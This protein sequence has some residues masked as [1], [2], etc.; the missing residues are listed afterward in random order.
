MA[1]TK[2]N[3]PSA[4]ESAMPTTAIRTATTHAPRGRTIAGLTLVSWGIVVAMWV[5]LSQV[6]S[7]V[8]AAI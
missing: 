8:A 7:L 4:E 6:F 3:L 1:S 2:R 5:G